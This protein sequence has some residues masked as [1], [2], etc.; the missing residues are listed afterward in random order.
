MTTIDLRSFYLAYV[1]A[2]NARAFDEMDR[3]VA[4][5]IA[6]GTAVYP[7]DAV[8]GSLAS[9]IDAVPDFRWEV[10]EVLVDGD[11]LAARLRNS[12]TPVKEW[13][14]VSPT[15]ASFDVAEHAIYRVADGRFVEMMNLHDSAEVARQLRGA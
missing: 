2:L 10:E 15:G 14:G 12:G 6:F 1:D 5:E 13:N 8:A 11:R 7:R 3:F 9:I 4:D